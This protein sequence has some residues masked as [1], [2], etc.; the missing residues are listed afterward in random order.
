MTLQVSA[1]QISINNA[2]GQEKFNSGQSLVFRKAFASGSGVT[3]NASTQRVI[4][5]NQISQLVAGDFPVF[6]ITITSAT[7]NG[8]SSMLNIK[9]PA[10][11][12]VFLHQSIST[13]NST[14]TVE[15]EYFSCRTIGADVDFKATRHN[16]NGRPVNIQTSVT[17]NWEL[18]VYSVTS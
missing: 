1:S 11:G 8:A 10:S 9:Q 14:S 15:F 12:S 17:F 7:G 2:T 3:L 18:Y 6:Y 5:V 4:Y 13:S 16:E